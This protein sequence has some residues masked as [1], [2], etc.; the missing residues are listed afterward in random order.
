MK[1]HHVLAALA[2]IAV[3]AAPATAIGQDVPAPPEVEL[4]EMG[5][6]LPLRR[7]QPA[8]HDGMLV[9]QQDFAQIQ[10]DYD[11]MRWLLTR[12][13]ERDREQCESRVTEQTLHTTACEE[14]LS[15][16]DGL[17]T[18]R[19]R[20]WAERVAQE[21]RRAERQWHES[22]VLWF[23]IGAVATTVVFVAATVR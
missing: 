20:E 2:G 5:E 21:Q 4:P 8:P 7:G 19:Q 6:V 9:L 13:Q 10:T 17:W 1:W 14:R 22:P 12:T 11:R 15:L 16:R 18:E 23:A 3:L